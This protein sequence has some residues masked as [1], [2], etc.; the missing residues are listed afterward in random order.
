MQISLL[1][2]YQLYIDF[3]NLCP[4]PQLEWS[5][6][7]W[8]IASAQECINPQRIA[9][10]V[11]LHRAQHRRVGLSCGNILMMIGNSSRAAVGRWRINLGGCCSPKQFLRFRCIILGSDLAFRLQLQVTRS[12]SQSGAELFEKRLPLQCPKIEDKWENLLHQ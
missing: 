9:Y 6:L 7:E 12:L 1:V 5:I 4:E 11:R 10:R 8:L 2:W 3:L